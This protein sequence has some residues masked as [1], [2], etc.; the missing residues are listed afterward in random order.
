MSDVP[1]RSPVEVQKVYL[2]FYFFH[3]PLA[4]TK[5]HIVAFPAAFVMSQRVVQAH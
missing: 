4:A 5:L 1:L 3:L 2:F